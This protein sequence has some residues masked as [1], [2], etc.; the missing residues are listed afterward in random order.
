MVIGAENVCPVVI[1]NNGLGAAGKGRGVEPQV[2]KG[3]EDAC[4]MEVG[5]GGATGVARG[6]GEQRVVGEGVQQDVSTR[7]GD[8]IACCRM[9]RGTYTC[10]KIAS[11]KDKVHWAVLHT[12]LVDPSVNVM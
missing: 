5:E 10:I 3:R 9:N 2:V 4:G 6:G 7:I 1:V 11:P 12:H 8:C